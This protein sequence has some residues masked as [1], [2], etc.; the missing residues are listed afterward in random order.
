MRVENGAA[1]IGRES[2]QRWTT[3]YNVALRGKISAKLKV[4]AV[5]VLR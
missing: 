2:W 1:A 4:K 3:A 5:K